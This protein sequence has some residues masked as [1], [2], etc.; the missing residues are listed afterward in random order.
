M[1]EQ[2]M[3]AWHPCFIT[4]EQMICNASMSYSRNRL[5]SEIG[6]FPNRRVVQADSVGTKSTAHCNKS[7]SISI[8]KFSSF[9]ERKWYNLKNFTSAESDTLNNSVSVISVNFK[10]VSATAKPFSGLTT[11]VSETLQG[12]STQK[13]FWHL[14]GLRSV[15]TCCASFSCWHWNRIDTLSSAIRT[16]TSPKK[17]FPSPSST[18]IRVLGRLIF[19]ISSKETTQ[20]GT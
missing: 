10:S 12:F 18:T 19:V 13:I 3:R 20:S 1:S 9:W 8:M 15:R 16:C 7:S 4:S 17:M 2:K 11:T 14:A 5:W 6:R